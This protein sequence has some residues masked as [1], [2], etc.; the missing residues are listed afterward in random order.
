[1]ASFHKAY[2]IKKRLAGSMLRKRGVHGIGIGLKDP[3]HP[4]KGAAV[5][6]YVNTLSAAGV[7]KRTKKDHR[8][9]LHFLKLKST[10]GVPIR[11]VRSAKFHK[12]GTPPSKQNFKGRIRPLI[13]GYSIGTT[14][15][16]G[17]AGLIVSPKRCPRIRNILSNNH[18]LANENSCRNSPTLQPGGADGGTLKRDLIGHMNRFVKLHKRKAN[19]LDAATSKPLRRNLLKP[20]YAVFGTVP[21]HVCS[22]RVGDRFKKVGRTSGVVT[23]IVDSIHTDIQVGYGGYGNLGT[24]TFKNQSVIRGQR[25]VSLPGDSGSVWLTRRGNL[26][27]AVNF[28]GSGDGRLSISYPVEWF[29][30]VFGDRVAHSRSRGIVRPRKRSKKNY[31]FTR[32]LNPRILSKIKVLRPSRKGSKCK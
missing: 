24:I 19:Y 18:V 13:G 8:S 7:K 26:A 17:T 16:S 32:P 28:A 15:E 2:Q 22:Y 14:E 1:M 3:A 5:V 9:S 10:A 27:A 20:R 30:Q 11:I 4:K 25:P 23:G 31:L 12:N 29:M 6:V 21:G